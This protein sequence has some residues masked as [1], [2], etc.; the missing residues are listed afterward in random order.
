[1][2][3]TYDEITRWPQW[4]QRL[5]VWKPWVRMKALACLCAALVLVPIGLVYGKIVGEKPHG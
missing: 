1:V 3:V 2:R 5:Y 4:R